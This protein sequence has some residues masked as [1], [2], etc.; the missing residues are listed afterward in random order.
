MIEVQQLTKRFGAI[1]AVD[2]VSFTAR[3]GH[4]TALV[5]PNGAGKTTTLR[6]LL[7]LAHP[8]SGL[9]TVSG[10]RYADLPTPLTAV[11]AV[12]E[13]SGFHPSRT[14]RTHLTALALAAGLP[15]DRVGHVLDLVE[16]TY[17]TDRRVGR[18]SLGMRQRLGL[19]AA[20]LGEPTTLVLDEPHNG[21]D[22]KGTRWLRQRLRGFAAEGRTV[23]VAS[24]LL[25]EMSEV[26]DDVIVLSGGRVVLQSPLDEVLARHASASHG[27][28]ARLE[29]VFLQLTDAME[30]K[31]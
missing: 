27:A 29:D 16:L 30:A 9:A 10:V 1:T 19:A 17:A 12:L 25:T 31:S 15:A 18:Y 26:A 14:A 11:G 23:L 5:G 24:H 28:P 20:L 7:G 4:V 8:T 21:L 2:D 3:P 6:M 22:P 13:E